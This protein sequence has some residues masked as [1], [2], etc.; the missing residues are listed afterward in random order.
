MKYWFDDPK[1]RQA[2]FDCALE[3][4]RNQIVTLPERVGPER[5]PV[6]MYTNRV[7]MTIVRRWLRKD[8]L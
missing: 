3:Q 2:L 1:A 8:D 4:Y 6:P 7:T 5:P